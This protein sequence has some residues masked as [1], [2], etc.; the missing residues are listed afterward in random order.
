MTLE[1]PPLSDALILVVDDEPSNVTLLEKILRTSGYTHVH[2]TTDSREAEAKVRSL[3]PDLLLLDLQ[4]PHFDG[5][6]VMRALGAL[7]EARGMPILVLTADIS[8]KVKHASLSMGSKDF[9]TKPLDPIEV[10]LRIKNL[11]E[12]KFLQQQLKD[13]NELL[14]LHVRDRTKELWSSVR[15]LE[16][17]ENDLVKSQEE[18][19]RRL[20]IAAEFR[21][22]ETA[23]HI[24]RMSHYCGFLAAQAGCDEVTS[25][26]IRT[27]SQM[28]DVGKIGMPDSILLKAGKLTPE[29]R[30]IMEHHA[31]DG[32]KVLR[33]SHAD[34]LQLAATI[35]LN[36]HERFDG[37]GYPR[38][39][40]GN[41]IPQVGRIAAIADVFDALVVRSGLS[42][43]VP[44][45][46][47]VADDARRARDPVRRRAFGSV[48]RFDGR[49]PRDHGCRPREDGF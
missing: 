49:C 16:K 8:T 27:A 35:A 11:L 9:L 36:H 25:R 6:E 47:G 22:D 10:M 19:V 40:R 34:L 26:A 28:H 33:G 4:M 20:S 5:F 32:W 15:R 48:P 43:G 31:E 7:P 23:R 29:E 14:E 12:T 37:T 46:G 38:K 1:N 13:H 18:T 21:D 44:V 42:A 41:E 45:A 3:K 2:S 39:L 30:A 17:A 24:V